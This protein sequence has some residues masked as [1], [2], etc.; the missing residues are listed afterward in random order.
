MPNTR[1]KASK[2]NMQNDQYKKHVSRSDKET[3][4]EV[5][6]T[7]EDGAPERINTK[8]S[9]IDKTIADNTIS[10]AQEEAMVLD[11]PEPKEHPLSS[12]IDISSRDQPKDVN[13]TPIINTTEDMHIDQQNDNT[14]KDNSAS[15]SITQQTP[16]TNIPPEKSNTNIFKEFCSRLDS[17]FKFFFTRD[18]FDKEK[19]NNEIINSIK[20]AFLTIHD[21]VEF[22][23]QRFTTIECYTVLIATEKTFNE[24]KDK[25]IALLNHITPNIFSKQIIDQLINDSLNDLQEKSLTISNVLIKY[26]TN[27]LIKHI[28]NFTK[29]A[30]S[31]HKELIPKT[32]SRFNNRPYPNRIR[33]NTSTA[34][35][36]KVIV[37]FEKKRA[38][39]YL[40]SQH[41]WGLLIENFIIRILPFN[42]DSEEYKKRTTSSYVVTGIPLNAHA[43]YMIPLVNHLN[44]RSIEILPTKPVSLHKIAYLYADITK[45]DHSYPTIKFD[46]DF[47]GFKLFIFPFKVFILNNTC[48]FCGN[49]GHNIYDCKES[50][51]IIL[52]H[53]QEKRFRKKLLKRNNYYTIDEDK[54][55]SYNKVKLIM[56]SKKNRPEPYSKDNNP[57]SNQ[58]RQPPNWNNRPQGN[59][60]N[61]NTDRRQHYSYY[62][63]SMDNIHNCDE[64]YESN[65]NNGSSSR[66]GKSATVPIPHKDNQPTYSTDEIEKLHN[67][68]A[69]QDAIIKDLC[70]QIKSLNVK[71]K[72]HGEYIKLLQQ[73]E[74]SNTKKTEQL[75]QKINQIN[76][77]ITQQQLHIGQIPEIHEILMDIRNRGLIATPVY[78]TMDYAYGHQNYAHPSYNE[79]FVNERQLNDN[80]NFTNPNSGYESSDIVD[81]RHISYSADYTPSGP[82]RNMTRSTSLTST[83]SN[84]V[85]NIFGRSHSDRH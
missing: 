22:E 84:T 40:L 25:P 66:N 9:K 71:Q 62:T 39:Q 78:P 64:P 6:G 67:K 48:G 61:K 53:N 24:L 14:N 37:T 49:N 35:Y 18:Q 8:C 51:Y 79:E 16:N 28:A 70:G 47:N 57:R 23:Y 12:E 68:I 21:A 81:D 15:A 54:K 20:N 42:E 55:S 72:E 38:A 11:P 82:P 77:T 52:P 69:Q 13:E 30:I 50:D 19:S 4:E 59:Q 5:Y 74:I 76:D 44:A 7:D 73:Q 58:T 56:T 60:R 29:A 83:F 36:K 45:D 26:D 43:I 85:N 1:S 33:L 17:E 2:H 31:S 65:N 80:D 27:L 41:K 63:P 75:S 34:T 32:S 46:T 3:V 10:P